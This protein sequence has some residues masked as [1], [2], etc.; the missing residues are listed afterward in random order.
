MSDTRPPRRLTALE[1]EAVL[2]RAAEL[3]RDGAPV[4]PGYEIEALAEAAA[5]VG[6]D[7]RAVSRAV[8]ELDAGALAG[9]YDDH[10]L[11]PATVAEQRFVAAPPEVAGRAV[12]SFLERQTFRAVR[13]DHRTTVFERRDDMVATLRRTFDLRKSIVLDDVSRLTATVVGVD[14]GSLVRLEAD[15]RASR[16][17]LGLSMVGVPAVA[18]TGAGVAL[19]VLTGD[20]VWPALV[21]PGSMGL[22][23]AGAA[24]GR[25]V[26]ARNR[27]R[28]A[29]VLAGFLDDLEHDRVPRGRRAFGL[30]FHIPGLD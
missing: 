11:G 4:A 22:A 20:L 8:A 1:A 9:A 14:D 3:E 12:T 24:G 10:F 16:R 28:T 26:L 29:Q 2:A 18:G 6:I 13:Q 30:P 21:V 17:G 25:R 5:E 23:G 19:G 27:R 7:R 15:L